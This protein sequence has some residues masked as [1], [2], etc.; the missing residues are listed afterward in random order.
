V[1]IAMHCNLKAAHSIAPVV[2]A[3]W[4]KY[5]PRMRRNCYIWAAFYGSPWD[6]A[7]DIS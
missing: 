1:A 5:V 2:L 4:T 3:V 7:T 6:S